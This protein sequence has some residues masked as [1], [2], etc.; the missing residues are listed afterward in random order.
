MTQ[1]S[2]DETLMDEKIITSTNRWKPEKQQTLDENIITSI[3][4]R[5]PEKHQTLD[6][7]IITSINRWKPE[8]Q[9]T[10]DE[11][12]ITSSPGKPESDKLLAVDGAFG[13]KGH[14]YNQLCILFLCFLA[15]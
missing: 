11:N 2:V 1:N 7:N 8:K 3:N 15:G 4:R 5:K 13:R 9:Q 6:E 10:L 14:V 12:I